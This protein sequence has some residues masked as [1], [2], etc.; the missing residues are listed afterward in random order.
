MRR[1]KVPSLSTALLSF[2][3]RAEWR[4]WLQ[5]NHNTA[6]QAWIAHYQE[7]LGK[8][9]V[10]YQ[11]AVEEALCFGWIDGKKKS[12]DNERYAYRYTPRGPKS[13]W[14][15]RNIQRAEEL[16]AAQ[17]MQP[18][19]LQAFANHETRGIPARPSI[20]PKDIEG[21]FRKNEAAWNNFDQFPPGFKKLCIGWVASAKR[22][23]TQLRRLDKLVSLSRKNL[24][25]KFM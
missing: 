7:V 8:V 2:K 16:I 6:T 10:S 9:S 25:M 11:E 21:V 13:R 23:E 12:I 18:A 3:T 20:L 5:A 14:S 24:K 4:V 1:S 22:E 19:G 15:A 17:K